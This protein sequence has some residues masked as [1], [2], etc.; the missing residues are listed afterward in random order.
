[1]CLYPF[2]LKKVDSFLGCGKCSECL[3]TYSTEFAVR[4]MLEAKEHKQ[5]CFVTLTYNNENLPSELSKRDLQLFTKKLRY[6]LSEKGIT[7]RLFQCGE[8]GE[9]NARPHYHMIIFGWSPDDLSFLYTTKKGQMIYNSPFLA[10]I[11]GKGFVSVGE[12]SFEAARYCAKY[13]Q[14]L[15]YDDKGIAKP[16]ILSS[17]RPGIGGLQPTL[18]YIKRNLIS[19]KVYLNGEIYPIP[20]YYLKLLEKSGDYAETI[21]SIRERRASLVTVRDEKQLMFDRAKFVNFTGENSSKREW[22][23]NNEEFL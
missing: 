23:K 4:C 15:A 10:S 21:K 19:D 13:M 11:W 2:Y 16:F 1:M 20:H 3:K 18:D 6:H 17:R 14:K 8:Y 9:K 7:I 22:L 12:L 5:N